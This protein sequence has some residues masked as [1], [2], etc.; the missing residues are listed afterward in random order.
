MNENYIAPE[1][2]DETIFPSCRHCS[3]TFSSIK[4]KIRFYQGDCPYCGLNPSVFQP[5]PKGNET[6][7]SSIAAWAALHG[8]IEKCLKNCFLKLKKK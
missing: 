5:N 4:E 1:A 2:L 7:G 8:K 3:K 6:S